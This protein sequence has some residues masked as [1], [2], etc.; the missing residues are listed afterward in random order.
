MKTVRRLYFYAVAFFSLE[1]VL[2]GLI[3]LLRTTFNAPEFGS[4]EALAQAL[5]LI[6][7]GVPIFLVHWSWAQHAASQDEEEKI[8]GLRAVFFHAVLL[9]T[10]V[11]VVQNLLAL[12][13][14]LLLGAARISVERALLGGYQTWPDN[15]IAILMNTLVAAYFWNVLRGEWK[16]LPETET[17]S[18][19]GGLYGY[20]WVLYSLLM[21]VFGG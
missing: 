11:P 16:T 6:L 7:V 8:S 4:A 19:G 14:R 21:V 10:L 3:G 1:V 5:A 2:W 12:I 15:L 20:I 9:S 17:F 18:D 13:D